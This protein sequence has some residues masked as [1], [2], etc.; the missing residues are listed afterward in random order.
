MTVPMDSSS[1]TAPAGSSSAPA[2]GGSSSNYP[3]DSAPSTPRVSSSAYPPAT[4]PY[5]PSGSHQHGTSSHQDGINPETAALLTAAAA[6]GRQD[7]VQL[8]RDAKLVSLLLQSMGVEDYEPRVVPQLLEFMHRYV[9]DILGDAQTYAE[10]ANHHAISLDD[11][12]IAIEGRAAHSFTNP[13]R[14]E[15]LE[16][17]AGK[18]N[19]VPLP[20]IP[21]KFG[22]RLPPERHT[23]TSTN[24][25]ISV[26]PS[27]ASASSYPASPS[28][29]ARHPPPA[30]AGPG[31]VPA[32]SIYT[33]PPPMLPPM[34]SAS[35]PKDRNDD[36]DDEEEGGDPMQM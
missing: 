8:P 12:R 17:V 3:P 30:S 31:F 5:T 4:V 35:A 21:E 18:K 11:V 23:L 28:L 15:F 27:N 22:V 24:F 25:Q 19:S 10:H 14:R 32:P 29:S 20:L 2:N 7:A 6:H 13:P 26:K 9:L 1:T 16:A 36:Y 34:P 33:Q